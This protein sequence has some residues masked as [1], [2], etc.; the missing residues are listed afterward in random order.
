MNTSFGSWRF[1]N[2]YGA[3]G[4]ITRVRE[5]VIIQGTHA[6][7]DKH[8]DNDVWKEYFF[9]VKP[10]EVSRCPPWI[11]PYH[12]RLDWLLWF[13]PFSDPRRNPWV[14]HLFGKLMANDSKLLKLIR[15]NPFHAENPPKYIRAELYKYEYT[16]P[17][18]EAA[19]KGDWWER[20]RMRSYIA[21]H[22]LDDLG[23]IY[24]QFGWPSEELPQNPKDT[25][26]EPEDKGGDMS[27]DSC[28]SASASASDIS[29]SSL[30][31]GL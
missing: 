13:L 21:P 22:T 6:D 26:L 4:S 5:E 18:S 14:Y 20:T 12:Y 23:Y 29:K 1:V 3:F 19:N 8:W 10:G 7:P 25:Q 31:S 15:S 28:S 30:Q 9:K 27:N 2:T 16:R 17:G 11:S 24:D